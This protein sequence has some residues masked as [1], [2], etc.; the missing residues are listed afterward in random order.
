MAKYRSKSKQN[1][2]KK[3]KGKG[4]RRR[5]SMKKRG[6]NGDENAI[7]IKFLPYGQQEPL[8]EYSA[9]TS[10]S[11]KIIAHLSLGKD[12]VGDLRQFTGDSNKYIY[13]YLFDH[14]TEATKLGDGSGCNY[15][16]L[17][18]NADKAKADKLNEFLTLTYYPT[19]GGTGETE[20]TLS[21]IQ[22]KKPNDRTNPNVI[23][24]DSEK[25]A[26]LIYEIRSNGKNVG[27][28][29][30]CTDDTHVIKKKKEEAAKEGEEVA[31]EGKKVAKEGEEV[32]EEGQES[33]EL[34]ENKHGIQ[35]IHD[36]AM[37][38]LTDVVP[39]EKNS[40]PQNSFYKPFED[41]A[42]VCPSTKYR[43]PVPLKQGEGICL[44]SGKSDFKEVKIFHKGFLITR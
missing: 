34:V 39:P 32:A 29:M 14:N 7:F 3:S 21:K 20:L 42:P 36:I 38:N 25:K 23:K 16:F 1:Y 37:I 5:K 28:I 18:Y 31:E 33:K 11:D 22:C 13:L 41:P 30:R 19:T 10:D 40:E 43:I 6:G 8:T 26:E 24:L 15:T 27:Y 44:L 2:R 4:K 35:I 9:T 17:N 12:K